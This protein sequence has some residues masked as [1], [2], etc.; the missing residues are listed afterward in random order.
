KLAVSGPQLEAVGLAMVG[1]V[2]AEA[3]HV[4]AGDLLRHVSVYQLLDRGA[5][6]RRGAEPPLAEDA[7]AE[8]PA[9]AAPGRCHELDAAV[10]HVDEE[11]ADTGNRCM[12]G[13]GERDAARP[14]GWRGL[15]PVSG[16]ADDGLRREGSS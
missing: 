2:V 13:L 5:E 4:G 12:I 14:A 1:E 10:H 9:L 15:R 16:A 7:V 3:Q 11:A 8:R 6:L